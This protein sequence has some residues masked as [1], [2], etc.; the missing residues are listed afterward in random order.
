M[1]LRIE[2]GAYFAFKLLHICFM[3]LKSY[4]R[5]DKGSQGDGLHFGT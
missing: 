4:L 3:L 2:K 1:A 5:I